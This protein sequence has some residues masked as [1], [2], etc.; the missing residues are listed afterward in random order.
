MYVC[1]K[2]C[3][4]IDIYCFMTRQFPDIME[5]SLML[6]CKGFFIIKS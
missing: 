2:K 1:A 4:C 6:I 5:M 3:V